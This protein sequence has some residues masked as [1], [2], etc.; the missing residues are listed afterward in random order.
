[1]NWITQ[2]ES[3]V[4]IKTT[5]FQIQEQLVTKQAINKFIL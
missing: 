3:I 1:M 5:T 4:N 2:P